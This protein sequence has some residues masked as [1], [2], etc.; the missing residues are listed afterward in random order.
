VI[1]AVGTHFSLEDFL[2]KGR[3]GMASTFLTRLR[4]GSKLVDAKGI[5]HLWSRQTLRL[6]EIALIIFAAATPIAAALLLS[7]PGQ[8]LL[9]TLR[10]WFRFHFR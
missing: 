3:K 6:G 9:R 4:I 2:D 7:S 1:V 5:A 8:N 10:L